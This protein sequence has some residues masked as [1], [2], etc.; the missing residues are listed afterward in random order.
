MS[1]KNYD[2]A[3]TVFSPDGHLFQVE[4]ALEAVRKGTAA[5]GVQGKDIVVL[6]VEKRSTVKLQEPRTVR[7]ICVLDDHVC[8]TFAGLTADARVLV[9]RARIE[10]QS[11]R[12]TVEDPV[13]VEYIT[14]Y[15]AGVQQKY[16]QS[17]GVRPFGIST[18]IMGFD[19]DGT[20]RLYQTDPSGTYSAWKANAT[21]R[22]SK[23]V[24]EFLEKHYTDAV[25]GNDDEVVRLAIR[26]LLEVVQSGGKHIEIAVMRRGQ[27]L[28]M[29]AQEQVDTIVEAIEKEKEEEAE[30]KKSKK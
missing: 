29:L 9:N 15:I 17:G 6:A 21:G 30:K 11:H 13:T 12:L 1:A 8:M 24:R 2:R 10:C 18:L 5:V 19:Y 27:P 3:I 20:P 14:R 16:T 25:A 26:A 22:S 28:E 23:T 7:K 4:Y